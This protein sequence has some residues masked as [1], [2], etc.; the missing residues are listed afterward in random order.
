MSNRFASAIIACVGIV[1]YRQHH[2]DRIGARGPRLGDLPQVD[3]EVLRENRP[4]EVPPSGGDIVQRTAEVSR[5]RKHAE[6]V[7]DGR[8]GLRDRADICGEA[9]RAF[10]WRGLLD[11]EDEAGSGPDD[12]RGEAAVRPCGGG[13]QGVQRHA[14]IARFQVRPLASDD[15]AENALSHGWPR[16]RRAALPTQPRGDR[17]PSQRGAFTQGRRPACSRQQ[18]SRVEDDDVFLRL[19]AAPGEQRLE[20][21]SV[22]LDIAAGHHLE[23]RSLETGILRHDLELLNLAA[24]KP[25]SARLTV[26]GHFVEP[27]TMDH[28][29][30]VHAN[31]VERLGDPTKHLRVGDAEQLNRRPGRIDAGAE[32]VHDRPH[33]EL[34]P[35]QGSMLHA[36]MIGRREQE[37]ETRL[38]EQIA[39]LVRR[40]L[41]CRADGFENVSRSAARTDA[42]IAMLGHG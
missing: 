21:R 38:V 3:E 16:R 15:L 10:R 28:Q 40:N 14:V 26:Q 41:D 24:G 25:H 18:R 36:R 20:P 23:R 7:G 31:R 35:H 2:Q 34:P 17:F 39:R 6:R 4:V 5:V 27:R 12:R 37:A 33:L 11:L 1:E 22:L 9:D 32:Q 30:F 42:A 8:I 19:S 13:P 29:G